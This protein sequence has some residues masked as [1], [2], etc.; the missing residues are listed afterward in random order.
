MTPELDAVI[1]EFLAV[2]PSLFQIVRLK[3]NVGIG[4]AANKGLDYVKNELVAKMDSDDI[5]LSSRCEKLLSKFKSNGNFAIVGSYLTEFENDQENAVSIRKVPV[6][7][8]QIRQFAKRRSPFNNQTIMYKK[9]KILECGAYSN[10]RRVEDYELF[11]RV[12]QK[13]YECANLPESLVMYRLGD[14]AVERRFTL[15]NLKGFV[16]VR[17]RVLKSG[18]GNIIDFLVPVICQILLMLV[19]NVIRKK[20]Y[21]QYLREKV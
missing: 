9:A 4:A 15:E 2:H 16:G 12:L 8:E 1:E 3:E 7:S 5:S 11:L 21:V 19:P 18:Y 10:F 6:S 13:G 14:G 20:I 17:W